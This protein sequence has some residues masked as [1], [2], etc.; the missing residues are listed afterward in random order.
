LAL[1]EAQQALPACWQLPVEL[2]ELS[3]ALE[4]ERP[5]LLEDAR[6]A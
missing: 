2:W 6:A 1:P 5:S 4:A 3:V